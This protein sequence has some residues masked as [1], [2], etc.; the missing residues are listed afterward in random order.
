MF[1]QV[2]QLQTLV[3]EKSP[4]SRQTIS[5]ISWTNFQM[6]TNE[7]LSALDAILR[8]ELLVLTTEAQKICDDFYIWQKEIN[9][10]LPEK[11]QTH[12]FARVLLRDNSLTIDW[13]YQ[14]TYKD[15]VTKKR[16]THSKRVVPAHKYRLSANQWKKQPKWLQERMSSVEKDLSLIR[17]RID[18]L[19]QIRQSVRNYKDVVVRTRNAKKKELDLEALPVPRITVKRQEKPS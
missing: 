1:V 17:E 6:L 13:I 7:N 19:A 3:T 4:A 8:N 15:K 14:R 16:F 12:L 18:Y 11:D 10:T 2:D 5:D 9:S